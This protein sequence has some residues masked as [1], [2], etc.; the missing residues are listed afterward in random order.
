M[1]L[2]TFR[3]LSLFVLYNLHI[4]TYWHLAY[5]CHECAFNAFC[6]MGVWLQVQAFGKS[7][8]SATSVTRRCFATSGMICRVSF[9][10]DYCSNYLHSLLNLFLSIPVCANVMHVVW[11]TLILPFGRRV[12]L[13]RSLFYTLM[14]QLMFYRWF[15]HCLSV[16]LFSFL[17]TINAICPY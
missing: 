3:K 7:L 16:F 9:D 17:S 12:I 8:V 2:C 5:L 13:I 15:L 1:S 10:Y 11:C 14:S 4:N 6:F